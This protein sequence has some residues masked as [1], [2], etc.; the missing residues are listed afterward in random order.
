MRFEMTN[1]SKAIAGLGCIA[2]AFWGYEHSIDG[3]VWLVVLG[4]LI[5]L[6]LK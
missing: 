1:L 4:V 3:S 6:D 5:L 2:L